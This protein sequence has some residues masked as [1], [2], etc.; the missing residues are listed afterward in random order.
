M[1]KVDG[2]IRVASVLMIPLITLHGVA[3]EFCFQNSL[4]G[5]IP[6]L[7]RHIRRAPAEPMEHYLTREGA[8]REQQPLL[9]PRIGH[10][11]GDMGIDPT[12]KK[13]TPL[14][15]SNT[16]RLFGVVISHDCDIWKKIM[17]S[18]LISTSKDRQSHPVPLGRDLAS[19]H[20]DFC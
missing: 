5:A 10:Q 13:Y 14:R 8:L 3:T 7:G 18:L 19:V 20:T 6:L 1:E 16:R 17:R 11:E 9:P 4:A 2:R 12:F 15:S